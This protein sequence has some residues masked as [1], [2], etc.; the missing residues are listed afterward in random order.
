MGKIDF[1]H[2]A[3]FAQRS[4][5]KISV[6]VWLKWIAV[7]IFL[8]TNIFKYLSFLCELFVFLK[9]H[10]YNLL[11]FLI[12][13][14]MENLYAL[15]FFFLKLGVLKYKIL[16]SICNTTCA[17]QKLLFMNENDLRVIQVLGCDYFSSFQC[18]F[19]F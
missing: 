3:K 13:I 19:K 5:E 11:F 15:V 10:C 6:N 14:T 7:G 2:Y 4:K 12:R 17:F 8:A 9:F 1:I 18:Q 16:G